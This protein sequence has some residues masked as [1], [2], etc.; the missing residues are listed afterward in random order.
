MFSYS[1]SHAY[2][3]KALTSLVMLSNLILLILALQR[4]FVHKVS[5]S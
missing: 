3:F 4:S 1:H 2:A 5:S